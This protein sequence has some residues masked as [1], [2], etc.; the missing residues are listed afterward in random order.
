MWP[1]PASSNHCS[2][3]FSLKSTALA[4]TNGKRH[5]GFV[6]LCLAYFTKHNDLWF[7]P[8]CHTEH[9][10]SFFLWL[11][12]TLNTYHILF[13]CWSSMSISGEFLSWLPWTVLQIHGVQLFL[14][15]H[16]FISFGYISRSRLVGSHIVHLFLSFFEEPVLFYIMAVLAYTST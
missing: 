2:T 4:S 6:F 15:H 1:F 16:N 8:L 14:S 10:I 3:L 12:N 13:I 7:H 9:R 5:V 11:N